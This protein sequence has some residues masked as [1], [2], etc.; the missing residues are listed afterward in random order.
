M[1]ESNARRERRAAAAV[2]AATLAV[3]AAG[4]AGARAGSGPR[5]PERDAE[6]VAR[7]PA[8]ASE[9]AAQERER[10]RRALAA[11][12][13]D[14]GAAVRLAWLDLG[15]A[16]A[17]ADPRFLGRAE[18]A[19]GPWWEL[20]APPPEVLLLRATIR[21]WRHEFEPA[22][23]DLD[24]LVAVEPANAQGWLTRAVVL[25]V[26]GRYPEA[27]A[28]CAHLGTEFWT[29][30]CRAPLLGVTG[31]AASAASALAASLEHAPGPVEAAWARSLLADLA[32]WSGDER[33]A[34]ALLRASLA[35]APADRGAR[36]ALADL[37]L[38]RG[39]AAEA[40]ALA[41]G[42]EG[43]DALLLRRALA[44]AGAGARR[45]PAVPAMAARFEASRARGDAV[46]R[47][48]EARFVLAVD[49]DP[50]H[51]LRLA[52]DNWQIQREPADARLLMEAAL[53]AGA[54]DAAGPALAWLDETG[55]EWPRLRALAAA[56]RSRS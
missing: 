25:G 35:V 14:L 40:A 9:P 12:A 16:R 5:R 54:P 46:H 38:D 1:T 22:L 37:L 41:D 42:W 20:A 19:L 45:D 34:E 23:A 44:R 32:L 33:G 31:H 8:R 21:Q 50:A 26:R 29:A 48:E 4:I 3:I 18:A 36:V 27:L 13:R 15:A 7:V 17:G 10:L 24:R 28:S 51:A 43:D 56:L 6:V 30:A 2:V 55:C 47:R 11:D 53:A 52:R 39:R 49:R